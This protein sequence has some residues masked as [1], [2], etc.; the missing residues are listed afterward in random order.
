MTITNTSRIALT[1]DGDTENYSVARVNANWDRID[2]YIGVTK[3]TSSS[4]PTA[5][6]FD[7][8]VIYETDT[9]CMVVYRTDLVNWR[10]AGMAVVANATAR[11][12]LTPKHDGLMC[13][14]KDVDLVQVYNGS[15]WSAV[16][17]TKGFAPPSNVLPQTIAS[18]GG[19]VIAS[20]TIP[21]PGFTYRIGASASLH[22]NQSGGAS[23]P[24]SLGLQFR[25]N[26]TVWSDSSYHSKG[27]RPV[28]TNSAFTD[29]VINP[30]TMGSATYTGSNTVNLITK[31]LTSSASLA[32][33]AD[34]YTFE[35]VVVPVT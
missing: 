27:L 7:G 30:F 12:A 28:Y 26:A 11:D 21:D 34:G 20:L 24:C 19:G 25:I 6:L 3:C 32:L 13:Y 22:F 18:G 8:R 4:R 14:R 15:A 10:Y 5:N 1:K 29:M 17:P 9:E 33:S 23:A 2:E 31:N 16:T 35:T